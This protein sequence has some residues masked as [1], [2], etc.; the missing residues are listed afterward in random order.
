MKSSGKLMAV[1]DDFDITFTLKVA[2]EKRGYSVDV[3]NDPAEALVNFKPDYYGLLL[4]DV[5]MPQMNGFELYQEINK[6]D[7]KAKVC[8]FT[9]YEV[10]YDTLRTQFPNLKSGC[11]ITKPI[12][13]LEVVKKIDKELL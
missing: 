4:L 1:D 13:I 6:I 2:L 8:F 5:K 11:L 3:Y 9:A 12:S 7:R 10:F